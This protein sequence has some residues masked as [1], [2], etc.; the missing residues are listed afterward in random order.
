MA[1]SATKGIGSLV[2]MLFTGS[3]ILRIENLGKNEKNAL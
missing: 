2:R 3:I 1:F